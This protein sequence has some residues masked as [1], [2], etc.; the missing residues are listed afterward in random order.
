MQVKMDQKVDY[1]PKT[2]VD[3]QRQRYRLL[4]K[5]STNGLRI[6]R[7][8]LKKKSVNGI[9]KITSFAE[10]EERQEV[11]QILSLQQQTENIVCKMLKSEKDWRV[12]T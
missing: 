4:P 7:I 8:H 3:M 10:R 6:F 9:T 1:R 12:I 2:M 5:A 11:H